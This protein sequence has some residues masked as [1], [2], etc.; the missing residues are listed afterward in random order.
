VVELYANFAGEERWG[1]DDAP[2]TLLPAPL[3]TLLQAWRAALALAPALPGA[4]GAPGV[5][6]M[7]AWLN[8]PGAERHAA[9]RGKALAGSSAVVVDA[10]HDKAFVV[11]VVRR[12]GFLP[13]HLQG[14]I[15]VLDP[16]ALTVEG[17]VGLAGPAAAAG[18]AHRGFTAKP[19]RGSSGRGRVDL[20]NPAGI[21]GAL[22][23]LRRC[24]GVVVE[25]WLDRTLDLA[26]A[27][28]IDD[29]GHARLLGT[30]R[31]EVSG[32]GVWR[33]CSFVIDDAGL[34]RAAEP[35]WEPL[36]VEQSRIV[37]Q[38]AAARGYRGPCGVDAFV[39]VDVDGEPRL[40]VVELNA[41]FTAGL[42]G[43][44][45]ASGAAAG[46]RWCF[47]PR[48]RPELLVLRA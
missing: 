38:A 23:R 12:A 4:H 6:V 37:V 41:R 26:A 1:D 44:V 21:A 18:L 17:L 22:P 47:D 45:L 42:V 30:S 20:R 33:G 25:P 29:A 8:S 3:P 31:A 48:V 32:G 2:P 13:T 9:Q 36:L 40:R 16:A 11:D 19:R 24:G 15:H 34:P 43:V 10:V 5:D 27:W 28:W 14:A 7:V 35:A 39:F 46:S